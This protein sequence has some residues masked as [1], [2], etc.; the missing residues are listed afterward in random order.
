MSHRSYQLT[1]L[2]ETILGTSLLKL[3]WRYCHPDGVTPSGLH[4]QGSLWLQI[5]QWIETPLKWSFSEI[6]GPLLP[7]SS[8]FDKGRKEAFT[9]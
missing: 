3:N 1:K 5:R 9:N 7:L 6:L 8:V 2:P 4:F